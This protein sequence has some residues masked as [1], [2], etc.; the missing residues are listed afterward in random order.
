MYEKHYNMGKDGEGYTY[1]G[2]VDARQAGYKKD[3]YDYMKPTSRYGKKVETKKNKTGTGAP[4]TGI[5]GSATA[6]KRANTQNK[7]ERVS[8]SD[9]HYTASYGGPAGNPTNNSVGAYDGTDY[10]KGR[11]KKR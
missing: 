11:N 9:K 7:S 6:G 8:G 4:N 10:G 2:T 5:Q 3:M 1:P